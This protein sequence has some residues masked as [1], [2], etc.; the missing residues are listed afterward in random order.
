MKKGI[1]EFETKMHRK[2]DCLSVWKLIMLV[3]F[4]KDVLVVQTSKNS[5]YTMCEI[6]QIL[7]KHK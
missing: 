7:A 2:L 1:M 3:M 6:V 5:Y 4:L